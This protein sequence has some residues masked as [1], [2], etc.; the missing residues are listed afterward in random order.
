MSFNIPRRGRT[1][2]AWALRLLRA[3]PGGKA[4]GVTCTVASLNVPRL[5]T[6]RILLSITIMYSL[7]TVCPVKWTATQERS[8]LRGYPNVA[9][10]STANLQPNAVKILYL[11]FLWLPESLMSLQRL[12]LSLRRLIPPTSPDPTLLADLESLFLTSRQCS[13]KYQHLIPEVLNTAN[14]DELIDFEQ[15]VMWF[16][17]KNDK[18][19]DESAFGDNEEEKEEKW[20]KDWLDRMERREVQ[21]QIILHLFR[22][23]R[24]ISYPIAQSAGETSASPKKRKERNKP[25]TLSLEDKL[26][27]L[28]DKLAMWQLLRSIDDHGINASGSGKSEDN[29]DWMQIFCEE[30]VQ[31]TYSKLQPDM[32]ELLRSKVFR[33]SLFSDDTDSGTPPPDDQ[34][35]K[36][37]RQ[38]TL[39][40]ASPRSREP[41][42]SRTTSASTSMSRS[43]SVHPHLNSNS[44]SALARSRSLSISLEAEAKATT[45]GKKRVL[46]R[47]V[48]MSKGFKRS[49]SSAL[50][51]LPPEPPAPVVKEKPK[52]ARRDQG[53]ERTHSQVLVEDTPVKPIKQFTGNRP[54][55]VPL[56]TVTRVSTNGSRASSQ[57]SSSP[58]D[59]GEGR[60]FVTDTPVKSGRALRTSLQVAADLEGDEDGDDD[61]WMIG[62]P[63][64]RRSLALALADED[65]RSGSP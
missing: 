37:K 56:N 42:L 50:P 59:L 10:P 23:C 64:V 57:K 46:T 6:R 48:S 7:P 52:P 1:I 35:R 12:H 32:Y 13:E 16:A 22:L 58:L 19:P 63:S 61:E 65:A 47:E 55:P 15:S 40:A 3:R 14:P 9:G 2:C 41:S 28:M 31:E 11:Q 4:N 33:H 18:P 29:R 54:P 20:K 34:K 21:I 25:S 17:F 38:R 27:S 30:V 39:P 36:A 8:I 62:S 43:R 24:P 53:L 51:D 60:T 49:K 44:A 26:E 5:A 45:S